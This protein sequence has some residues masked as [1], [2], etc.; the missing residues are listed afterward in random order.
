MHESRVTSVS[1]QGNL[2]ASGSDDKLAQVW[3]METQRK[4][5]QFEH[6]D[7][8]YYPHGKFI[9][10]QKATKIQSVWRGYIQR[11]A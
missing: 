9:K 7:E 10:Y 11:K 1:V 6:E 4:L 2:I 3:N 8:V 5:W